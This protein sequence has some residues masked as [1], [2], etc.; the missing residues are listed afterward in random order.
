M[1]RTTG[2]LGLG[3]LVAI[4][5]SLAFGARSVDPATVLDA[6]FA[7]DPDSADHVVIRELRWPRTLL[8]ILA[9]AALAVAGA[10]T[11][12]ITR[13]PLGDPGVLGIN[14][15]AALAVVSAIAVFDLEVIGDMVWFGFGGAA[16][17]TVAVYV[18]GASALG[19]VS[20][21]RLTLAGAALSALLVSLTGAVA[22][23][24]NA[25]LDRFR[26]WVVGSLADRGTA[27]VPQIVVP[28]VLGLVA[29]WLL[30]RPLDGMALGEDVAVTLGIRPAGIRLAALAIVATL[31][32]A[33]VAAVGPIAF[34][35]LVAPHAMRSVVGTDH[36]RLLPAS[37]LVGAQLLIACDVAARL[38]LRP[39]ELRVGIVTAAIGGPVF[40]LVARRS[41]ALSAA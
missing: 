37:A 20:V 5:A 27:V 8:G 18:L 10:V 15:G 23:L 14:A 9:G 21:V 16:L 11:Q 38:V 6:V 32:G 1:T 13:N 33:A 25:A 41:Q 26:F 24:D 36:R 12:A 22:L 35:G 4:G 2:L 28:I 19:P 30:A 17:A 29:A 39:A 34:V 40:V 3:L 7:P 31:A